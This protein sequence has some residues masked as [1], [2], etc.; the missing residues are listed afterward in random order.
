MQIVVRIIES[1]V[2]GALTQSFIL[3]GGFILFGINGFMLVDG[4][5]LFNGL[6]LVVGLVDER[7]GAEFDYAVLFLVDGLY[8]F[9]FIIIGVSFS[10]LHF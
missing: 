6:I 1:H 2:L 7:D 5:V 9:V 10:V 8:F 3:F 4:I